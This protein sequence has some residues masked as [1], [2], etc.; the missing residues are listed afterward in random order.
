[1]VVGDGERDVSIERGAGSGPGKLADICLPR[2]ARTIAGAA[3]R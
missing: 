3:A 1:M 2:S